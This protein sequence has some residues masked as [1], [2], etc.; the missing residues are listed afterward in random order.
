MR[1]RQYLISKGICIIA[2]LVL[3]AVSILMRGE[4]RIESFDQG[5]TGE[6]INTWREKT[7]SE[8]FLVQD[9]SERIVS[10]GQEETVKTESLNFQLKKTEQISTQEIRSVRGV[11]KP[12]EVLNN[13]V[14]PRNRLPVF[15]L[16]L[17]LIGLIWEC[18]LKCQWVG[19]TEFK[20]KTCF[21]PNAS[22]R[23]GPPASAALF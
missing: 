14:Q 20:K 13:E 3:L 7:E 21:Y 18:N 11:Y 19:H 17:L 23:R 10:F 5:K 12:S 1:M 16:F 22:K 9:V 15:L 6:I 2:G 8:I 4:L